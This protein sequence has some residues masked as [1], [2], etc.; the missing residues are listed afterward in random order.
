[1]NSIKICYCKFR[2]RKWSLFFI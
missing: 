1:M 2:W